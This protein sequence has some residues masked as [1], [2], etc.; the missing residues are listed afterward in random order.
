MEIL[1]VKSESEGLKKL[2]KLLGVLDVLASKIAELEMITFLKYEDN[3]AAL[4]KKPIPSTSSIHSLSA[5]I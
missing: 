2:F 3:F 4:V 1:N 5:G